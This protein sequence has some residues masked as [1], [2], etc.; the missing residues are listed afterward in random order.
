M[1]VFHH[2]KPVFYVRGGCSPKPDVQCRKPKET[3]EENLI[4]VFVFCLT[5]DILWL[6]VSYL[7]GLLAWELSEGRELCPPHPCMSRALHTVGD[8]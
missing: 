1:A 4:V 6:S 3:I 8:Y 2:R 7:L 5:S